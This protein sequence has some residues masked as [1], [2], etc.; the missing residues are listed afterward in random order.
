MEE[1]QNIFEFLRTNKKLLNEYIEINISLFKLKF[2]KT[3]SN[4][5]GLLLWLIILI[6]FIF[7]ITIFSGITLGFFLANLLNSN[8][9][10]FA[11]VTGIILIMTLLLI[12]Y[13]KQ[14][15]INP[16]IRVLI[17]QYTDDDKE[18]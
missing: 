5:F 3:S 15:F 4:I 14:I 13:R 12:L 11:I 17:K 16:I 18:L 10:G 7:L 6:F 8:A 2:I 1:G 9:G